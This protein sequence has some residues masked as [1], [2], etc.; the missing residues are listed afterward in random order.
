[1]QRRTDEQTALTAEY[2][3]YL[4]DI[5]GVD[6]ALKYLDTC[7]VPRSILA[8]ALASPALRRH[9]E[10]RQQPRND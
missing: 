6:F 4:V 9:H 3:L 8:R 5:R 1:M 10:R 2:A 7:N